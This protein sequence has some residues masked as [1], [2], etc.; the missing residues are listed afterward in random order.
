[1]VL[2]VDA[3]RLT[4]QK[5]DRAPRQGLRLMRRVN[6]LSGTHGLRDLIG[7]HVFL[8][9]TWVHVDLTLYDGRT[10]NYMEPSPVGPV[11]SDEG[12]FPD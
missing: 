5:L 2:T 8:S 9:A 11:G 7:Q 3:W 10:L 1:V 4:F 6:Y 12:L